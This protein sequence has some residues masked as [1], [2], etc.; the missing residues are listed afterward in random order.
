MQVKNN[1]SFVSSKR[2]YLIQWPLFLLILSTTACSHKM[3]TKS[4]SKKN[5]FRVLGY[6][7]SRNNWGADIDS[8]DLAQVTD[9]NLAFL[10]PDT[11]GKLPSYPLLHDG[12][13]KAHDKDVRIY[14]SI[15]GGD[16]PPHLRS[17][18]EPAN[19][20][21][22]ID[23]LID[24][25]T[26]YDFDGIDVDIENALVNENYAGFVSELSR[27][28]KPLDKKMTA[29]LASWNANLIHDSTMQLYDY[30]N[31][32]SY[33]RTG[34]WSP[35]RPGQHS[36]L[37]M[38]KDDF[39]FYHNQRGIAAKKLLIGLPFYGYGFGSGVP[40]GSSY[41]NIISMYPGAEKVDSIVVTAGGTIYYN[42]MPTI[43][44]KVKFA[45]EQGAAGVMIWQ[46]K[47]DDPGRYSLLKLI[48]KI[49]R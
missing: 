33:D 18:M 25:I 22:F 45:R 30:I 31:I 29:A 12:V 41:R 40:S 7:F 48:N 39:N 21:K 17:L 13:R 34:P 15:G 14:M 32:M 38:A 46:L 3:G 5:D 23:G 42:G 26:T 4:P 19:R 49:A 9:L 36:P 8:I 35:N 28:L 24:A 6:L 11:S 16:P 27:R 20:T 37:S 10:N 2:Q 1:R 43:G 47:G 44:E